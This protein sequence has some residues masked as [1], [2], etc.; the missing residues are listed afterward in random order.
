MGHSL[1]S[2]PHRAL[3][4]KPIGVSA[5]HAAFACGCQLML[6]PA[7]TCCCL[8]PSSRSFAASYSADGIFIHVGGFC[9][10]SETEYSFLSALYAFPKKVLYSTRPADSRRAGAADGTAGSTPVVMRAT[11]LPSAS[12]YASLPA[13]DQQL[14]FDPTTPTAINPFNTFLLPSRPQT[15]EDV[16]EPFFVMGKVSASS[17][18]IARSPHLPANPASLVSLH[19]LAG[20]KPPWPSSNNHQVRLAVTCAVQACRPIKSSPAACSETPFVAPCLPRNCVTRIRR[21][22]AKGLLQCFK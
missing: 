18:C 19:M 1:S 17:H 14:D 2:S 8:L 22:H 20:A 15:K 13:K 4:H 5:S 11:Y 7:H 16:A 9:L 6:T 10:L 3:E 21:G 12:W